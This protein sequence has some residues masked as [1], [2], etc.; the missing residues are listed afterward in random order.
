M[1]LN[2][3]KPGL[4]PIKPNTIFLNSVLR[5]YARA[6]K[7]TAGQINKGNVIEHKSRQYMV[8]KIDSHF[9]GRGSAT[10]K[11][12]LKDIMTGKIIVERVRPNES[13]EV[14]TLNDKLYTYLY[15]DKKKVYL[16]DPETYEEI[17]IDV[18]KFEGNE[19]YLQLLE[20]DM[21]VTVSFL[22]TEKGLSP[23]SFRLPHMHAYEVVGTTPI[24]GNTSK[25]TAVKVVEIRDGI[26]IHVPEFVNV[27][28]KIFITLNDLKYFKRA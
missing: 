3:M 4:L 21:K 8:T 19:K 16:S 18:N 7:I 13:F 27:G 20:D 28:D 22:E 1:L 23:I 12:E 15:S 11:F 2:A 5:K 24:V 10:T 6:Y 14:S 26:Q 17:E 9:T 25:G